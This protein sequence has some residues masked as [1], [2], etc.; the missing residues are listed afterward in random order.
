MLLPLLI[1]Y[2]SL[3]RVIKVYLNFLL[4]LILLILVFSRLPIAVRM[5]MELRITMFII[6]SIFSTMYAVIKFNVMLQYQDTSHIHVV[7]T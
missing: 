7:E 5:L 4:I 3:I 2:W 1:C 6:L